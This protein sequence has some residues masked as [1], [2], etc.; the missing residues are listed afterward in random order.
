[1]INTWADGRALFHAN[2]ILLFGASP[3]EVRVR[4]KKSLISASK[5]RWAPRI[6]ESFSIAE[7]VRVRAVQPG[8]LLVSNLLLRDAG[9]DS[10][11]VISR[12]V[13]TPSHN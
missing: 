3:Q 8:V 10:R 7:G 6:E 12:T 4:S 2:A 9:W 13:R 1:M 5:N 11:I